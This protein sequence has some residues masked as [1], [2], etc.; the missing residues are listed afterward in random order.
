MALNKYIKFIEQNEISECLSKSSLV[1]SDFSSIIFDFMYR[2]K[3]FIIYIPDGEDP[4]IKEIYKNDYYEL[5]ESLKNGTIYFE[6]K[7]FY[8]NE[9]VNKII[10]YINNN[11]N[12]ESKLKLFYDSF[13][14]KRENSINKL[15]Y[16]LNNLN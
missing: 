14:F 2:N 4:Q 11:F 10:Y 3:P 8:I 9:T 13:H 16:Y 7:F 6:N 12:L 1:V 15:V 5:I